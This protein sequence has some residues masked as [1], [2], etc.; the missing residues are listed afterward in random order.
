MTF[1]LE[2]VLF[3]DDDANILAGYKRQL[4]SL[5]NIET[6]INGQQGLEILTLQGPF[7]VVVADYRMPGMDGN[8]FLSKA[9]EVSPD[10]VRMMLTGHAELSQAI[11]VINQGHIFRFLTKPCSQETL[12]KA[13][14]AG[15]EQYRL[16]TAERELL[17]KT[18]GHSIRLLTDVLS[19]ANPVAFSQM[20][21]IRKVARKITTSMRL[22]DSW[23]YE[24]AA[25]LSQIG[26]IALPSSVLEKMHAGETLLKGE[27][28]MFASHPTIGYKLLADIPRLGSVPLMVRDQQ[29]EFADFR[30]RKSASSDLQAELGAQ[31]I[32]TAVDYD[33]FIHGGM[34]HLE[35]VKKMAKYSRIYNPEIVQALGDEVILQG[36]FQVK[37]INVEEVGAGMIAN[38]DI[39]S[40]NGEIVVTKDQEISYLVLERLIFTSKESGV[41]EPFRVL[42]PNG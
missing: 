7:G 37:M 33:R 23:Q 26:C 21:N 31:I 40:K 12:V 24:L 29:K 20:L 34:M 30:N 1:M 22:L 2:S 35:V 19:L 11:E 41:I 10:T 5:Y 4:R 42:V 15:L 32:K 9:K 27:E 14:Q 3:V 39:R 17:E 28:S 6:A 13:L 36:E 16:I 25:M 18:L 38:E 8:Q